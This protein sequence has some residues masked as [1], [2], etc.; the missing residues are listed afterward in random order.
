MYTR[1]GNK[2]CTEGQLTGVY[3]QGVYKSSTALVSTVEKAING[4]NADYR[5]KSNK[6]WLK[7]EN[8][9]MKKISPCYNGCAVGVQ[10]DDYIG[11]MNGEWVYAKRVPAYETSDAT[12]LEYD[13]YRIPDVLCA[14]LENL[15]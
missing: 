3:I 11:T 13:M 2:V 12:V 1:E 6:L 15:L 4:F 5:I 8:Q 9:N 10:G 7:N 14:E